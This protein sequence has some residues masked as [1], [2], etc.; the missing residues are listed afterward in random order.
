VVALWD[1]YLDNFGGETCTDLEG[2]ENGAF[3]VTDELRAEFPEIPDK[4]K[5]T[6]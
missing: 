5:S 3:D 6:H 1:D 2:R 4:A